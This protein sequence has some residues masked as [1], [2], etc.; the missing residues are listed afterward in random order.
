MTLCTVIARR[1]IA[2]AIH[3]KGIDCHAKPKGLSRNDEGKIDCHDLLRK[4]RNDGVVSHC[5][6]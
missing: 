5:E 3:K 2:E 4:S 1:F 6:I